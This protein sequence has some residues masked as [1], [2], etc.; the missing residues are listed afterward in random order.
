[1][2]ENKKRLIADRDR[3]RAHTYDS[4]RYGFVVELFCEPSGENCRWF[5][6]CSVPLFWLEG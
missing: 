3:R 2:I 6:S 1:M 4:T 5:C